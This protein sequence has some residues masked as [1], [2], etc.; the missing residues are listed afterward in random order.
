MCALCQVSFASYK[1]WITPFFSWLRK[2]DSPDPRNIN[3][4]M[5]LWAI[6]TQGECK[7]SVWVIACIKQ[8]SRRVFTAPHFHL[9]WQFTDIST[10]CLNGRN[11]TDHVCPYICWFTRRKQHTH[12]TRNAD[13]VPRF[14]DHFKVQYRML[15][16][17][18]QVLIMPIKI[19]NHHC[20]WEYR[21]H[22]GDYHFVYH[23]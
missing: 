22:N 9:Q 20:R 4:G 14:P 19:L 3:V 11:V 15:Q 12:Y 13:L 10:L 5:A 17:S 7:E 16:G 2:C 8:L 6:N 21:L 1:H 23:Q 18:N